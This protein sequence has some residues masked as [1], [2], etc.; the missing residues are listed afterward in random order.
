MFGFNVD[1]NHKRYCSPIPKI[2]TSYVQLFH[3]LM[4]GE[5]N[6]TKRDEGHNKREYDR[7]C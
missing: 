6:W 5:L 3:E 2:M 1:I 7:N 4:G